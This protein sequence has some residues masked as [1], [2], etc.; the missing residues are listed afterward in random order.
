MK[1]TPAR[2][3]T[4][5]EL[6]HYGR[7]VRV[8]R[9]D[10]TADYSWLIGNRAVTQT[11]GSLFIEGYAKSNG[12]GIATITPRGRAALFARGLLA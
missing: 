4:L 10:Q 8:Y 9:S 6:A 7:A 5:H 11:L 1:L 2:I 12:D 3:R